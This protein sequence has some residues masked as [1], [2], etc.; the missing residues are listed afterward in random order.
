M[1]AAIRAQIWRARS[2]EVEGNRPLCDVCG[3]PLLQ[4]CD[5]HHAIVRR[6]IVRKAWPDILLDHEINI[7]LVHR[8]CHKKA[9]ADPD[10][11]AA[12]QI[13]RYGWHT[14]DQWIA[15]L[16]FKAPYQW[17][18]GLDERVAKLTVERRAPWIS[19]VT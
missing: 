16:P 1:D 13:V 4:S 8:G 18:R 17:H 15:S 10:L 7:C 19:T 2:W 5:F 6:G 11:L 9:H 3:R 12:I 14:I